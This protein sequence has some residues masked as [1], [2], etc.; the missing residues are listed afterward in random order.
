MAQIELLKLHC[1][2]PKRLCRGDQLRDSI[3][4]CEKPSP[5][6]FDAI[7]TIRSFWHVKKSNRGNQNTTILEVRPIGGTVNKADSP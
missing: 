5:E 1:P 3:L 6:C 7:N 4:S 2:Q